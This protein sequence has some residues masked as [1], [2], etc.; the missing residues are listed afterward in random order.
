MTTPAAPRSDRDV[1]DVLSEDHREVESLIAQIWTE[2]APDRRRELA[3]IMI[4][5]L[6]KH[7]VTEELFVYPVMRVNLP[8][9]PA[10][11]E[12]DVLE[13]EDLELTM[14]SL[15]SADPTT[16]AFDELVRHLEAVLTEH[17]T[18]EETTQFPQLRA[19]VDR[20]V[21]VRLG[22]QVTAAKAVVPT[23][24]HP[25]TPNSALAHAIVGP[26]VGLV[27]RLRDRFSGRPTS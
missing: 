20:D 26:G 19:A 24:P 4:A 22:E 18:G 1:V 12:R 25:S 27:D 6:V 13:H 9:G 7:S 11:V 21:L 23:R 15:E 10:A 2:T 8:D 16:P 3:D 14:K 5:E 17:V